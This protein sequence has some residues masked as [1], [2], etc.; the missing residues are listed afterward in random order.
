MTAL[1]PAAG[2]TVQ[3]IVEAFNVSAIT[4]LTEAKAASAIARLQ[5]LAKEPA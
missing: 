5:A 4:E 1:I 3:E 2:K